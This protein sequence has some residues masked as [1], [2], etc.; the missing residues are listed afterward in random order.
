ML[1]NGK[2]RRCDHDPLAFFPDGDGR[3]RRIVV[4]DLPCDLGHVVAIPGV[5]YMNDHMTDI[6]HGKPKV[7]IDPHEGCPFLGGCINTVMCADC[8]ETD[9]D[10]YVTAT[11]ICSCGPRKADGT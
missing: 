6:K 5:L 8:I 11:H 7:R 3:A 2:Y 10:W 1:R 9:P 4:V